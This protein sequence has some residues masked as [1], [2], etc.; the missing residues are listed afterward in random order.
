VVIYRQLKEFC[1]ISKGTPG[2]VILFKRNGNATLKAYTDAYFVGSA[3]NLRTSTW[4]CAF[5]DEIL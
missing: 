3:I 1:S 5:L 2:R 4:Y